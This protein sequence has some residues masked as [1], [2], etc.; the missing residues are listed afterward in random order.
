MT[1]FELVDRNLRACFR[2]LATRREYAE[3]RSTKGLDIL[4]LGV[5][6]QMFNAAFLATPVETA[7]DLE[8]RLTTAQVH[9]SARGVEW[10]FW[11]C[12]GWLPEA[13]RSQATHIFARSGLTLATQMPGMITGTLAKP[14]RQLPACI[15]REVDSGSVLEDFCEIGANCF[16][17]PQEWFDEVFDNETCQRLPF[18]AWVGYANGK[19]VGTSA[20]VVS[21]GAV[22]LYNVA[23]VP[24]FR[25]RGYAEAIM[26]EC[27]RRENAAGQPLPVVL[28]STNLGLQL[29]E[30]MGLHHATRFRVW[31][32]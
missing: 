17:V 18:R 10:S 1:D 6:F 12:D 8:R 19:A 5:R 11:L 4:S 15:V 16:R 32:S 28:Q 9:F 31:V 24:N 14:L 22:G 3:T 25:G 20:S 23:T 26:R 29:Y 2:A 21:G 30:Q 13:V 27:L 7:A